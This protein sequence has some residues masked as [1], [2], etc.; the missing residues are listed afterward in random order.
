M[1]AKVWQREC[2]TWP[3]SKELSE[4]LVVGGRVSI[5]DLH[6]PVELDPKTSKNAEATCESCEVEILHR[7][8]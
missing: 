6:K 3:A 8:L 1:P 7:G 2:V 4:L 5:S